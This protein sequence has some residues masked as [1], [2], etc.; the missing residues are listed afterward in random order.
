MKQ[1]ILLLIGFIT[2][3]VIEAQ[4][5]P[6]VGYYD[7]HPN[8]RVNFVRIGQFQISIHYKVDTATLLPFIDNETAHME[9]L[10]KCLNIAAANNIQLLVF[11]ELTLALSK[12]T[13]EKAMKLM[14]RFSTQHE[15]IIIGGTYYDS[16]RHG[17]C[18]TVL[19]EKT[20]LSY[21]IRPAIFEASSLKN[22]GMVGADSLYV[23]RTKYGNFMTLVCVDMISD[24]ANYMARYLSNRG[25]I[26][27]LFN[28]QYNS[29]PAE[30]LCEA[31]SMVMRHPLFAILTNEASSGYS[32][33]TGSLQPDQKK[34]VQTILP[35][36]FKDANNNTIDGYKNLLAVIEPKEEEALLYEINLC[37]IRVPRSTNAPDQGYPTLRN[38]QRIKIT[39][40][41]N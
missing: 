24:D 29:S 32:G 6:K 16:E 26:E 35:K 33:L 15:A 30:F 9:R 23:F 36:Y 18:V 37:C 34:T 3:G 17:R 4:N 38:L 5:L 25:E 10:E 28:I 19:P 31:S 14:Q 12:N 41:K 2:W 11:P 40:T 13:R 22:K 39:P 21:K 7:W 27:M 8:E 20:C 1:F